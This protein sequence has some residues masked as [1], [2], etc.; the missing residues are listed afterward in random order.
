MKWK[1]NNFSKNKLE[2][3]NNTMLLLSVIKKYY[4]NKE[5]TTNHVCQGKQL[6][7]FFAYSLLFF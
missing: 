2:K 4:R 6:M 3:Q 1:K 5:K 7:F